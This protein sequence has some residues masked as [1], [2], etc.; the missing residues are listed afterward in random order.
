MEDKVAWV[1]EQMALGTSKTDTKRKD[2]LAGQLADL[3]EKAD[4][5]K[6]CLED[7]DFTIRSRGTMEPPAQQQQQ[8]RQLQQQQQQQPAKPTPFKMPS[9][10][11]FPIWASFGCHE[12]LNM[13]QWF[14]SVARVCRGH[15]HLNEKDWATVVALLLPAGIYQDWVW[16]FIENAT[17]GADW[18]TLVEEFVA[19][20]QRQ[21]SMD[22]L[23][24]EWDE[25]RQ[26]YTCCEK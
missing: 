2:A 25:L 11:L 15:H 26:G 23:E 20:F 22:M 21:T 6:Q 4:V 7:L 19:R 3:Q 14:T 24:A 18:S 9:K 17:T 16:R 10:D 5:I 8:Q 13:R 12:P 1:N